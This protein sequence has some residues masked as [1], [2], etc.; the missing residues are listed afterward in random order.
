LG[1]VRALLVAVPVAVASCWCY[2]AA[3]VRQERVASESAGFLAR[4]RWW[5]AVGLTCLGAGLHVLALRYGALSVV[6]PLGAL[7]LVIAVRRRGAALTVAGLAGLLLLSGAAGP[8]Q[9]LG[10]GTALG[11]GGVTVLLIGLFAVMR[12]GLAFAAA[13]GIAS[14]VASALTQTVTV[15]FG[16]RGWGALATPTAALVA[17]LA[18][19]GL[20]L[21]QAGYRAGLGA[22]LAVLTIANPVAAGAIGIALLGE[23]FTGGVPGALL[24]LACAGLAAWG[25][26]ELSGD[27]P[28]RYRR[29]YGV[30]RRLLP[31]PR[32][33][34]P[35]PAGP[36]A[37]GARA[38]RGVLRRAHAHPGQ[39]GDPVRERW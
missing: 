27:L 6:Q 33:H 16:A 15:S 19:A 39:P 11:V 35:G 23:R 24:A 1:T 9:V 36:D 7:T 18:L 12:S 29:R 20:L 22:P 5:R 14:G 37:G 2:A 32:R 4:L 30:R 38:E 26:T 17:V 10:T 8:S 13:S 31:H 34:R 21:S 28:P 3:A 25:V